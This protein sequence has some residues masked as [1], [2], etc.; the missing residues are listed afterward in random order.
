V[1]LEASIFDASLCLK[2]LETSKGGHML[3]RRGP[4]RTPFCSDVSSEANLNGDASL[5]VRTA[6]RKGSAALR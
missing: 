5:V 1:K 4:Q 3:T 2:T 6:A